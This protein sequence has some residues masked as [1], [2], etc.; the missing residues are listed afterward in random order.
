[1]EK[2]KQ[3]SKLRITNNELRRNPKVSVVMATYNAREYLREAI[4]SVLNQTFK[5][6]EFV[7]IDDGST[8]DTREIIK[9]YEDPR[10]R[11]YKKD[12]RGLIAS[13]NEGIKLSRGEYVARMDADDISH[14]R[15]FEL[16]IKF[17]DSHPDYAMVGTTTEITDTEGRT[18]KISAEPL[19]HE[20]ILRGLL[21]RNVF[22]HGSM[23]ARREVLLEFD[24]YSPE[25]LHAEDYDLWARII[26]LYKGANLPQALFRWR[27]NP[28]GVTATKF[29]RQQQ[30]VEWI[31]SREWGIATRG[32]KFPEVSLREVWKRRRQRDPDDAFWHLR[33]DALSAI[34]ARLGR[35]FLVHGKRLRAI[36]SGL[37]SII[38]NP[39]ALRNYFYLLMALLPTGALVP[40]ENFLRPLK[41]R[42][43][44]TWR[45]VRPLSLIEIPEGGILFVRRGIYPGFDFPEAHQF[46]EE[47]VRQGKTVGV[48]CLSAGG[49]PSYEV[50]NGVKVFRLAPNAK[51]YRWIYQFL[52]VFNLWG[53]KYDIIH[54]FWGKGF[55]FLPLLAP[56]SAKK[57]VLDVRSGHIEESWTAKLIN[58]MIVVDSY[59][60]DHVITLDERLLEQVWGNFPEPDEV[61]FVPM[62][63]NTKL[64]RYRYDSK[65][66]ESLGLR[67]GDPIF[68]YQGTLDPAR[69]LDKFLRGF[70]QA[71]KKIARL[72]LLMV[73]DGG[74]RGELERLTRWL[75]IEDL[76]IFV[77]R[78]PFEEV[79]RYISLGDFGVSYVPQTP[80][81]TGQQVT[82]TLEYLACGRPVLATNLPFNK[83]VLNGNSGVLTDDDPQSVAR[84][85]EKIIRLWRDKK[86]SVD[87]D[88][89]KSSSWSSIVEEKLLPVY[90]F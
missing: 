32:G 83:E 27:S 17:L 5:D 64:F 25:A 2:R 16:Q 10:I 1:M 53:R 47:L 3:K 38:L 37:A 68:V 43:S 30:T 40:T 69:K 87:P 21:V 65:L 74:G 18:F 34:Y 9:S 45:R 77:G 70:A 52:L 56:W 36:K 89:V 59:L 20:D 48:V 26:R 49:E 82:K 31:T 13:L 24:G 71:K 19:S 42:L 11:L 75:G 84:G 61:S 28:K 7:I 23:M 51:F 58:F 4:E 22:A 8:D 33:K 29:R 86:L 46:A 12:H 44:G 78:V 63:V 80:A 76:V 14:P 72:K 55:S 62:G 67:R 6:F 73:G 81:F 39:I 50:I 60:F 90:G 66:A 79:P 85:I 57:W 35:S 88:I 15:R 41:S 54:V